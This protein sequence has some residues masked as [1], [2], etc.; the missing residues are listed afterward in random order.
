[1]SHFVSAKEAAAMLEVSL[2]TLYAYTSR[3][4]LRSEPEP[5]K[6]RE[7]RYHREDVERLCDRKE[8]RR[9]PEQAGARGLHWGSPVL[10]SSITLIDGGRLYY[11]GRDA[12]EFART[13][14]LEE[15]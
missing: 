1:M 3:G 9:N 4:Q 5:G 7:R 6:P 14:T 2:A 12:L 10:S 11:R 13:A 8:A 15:T